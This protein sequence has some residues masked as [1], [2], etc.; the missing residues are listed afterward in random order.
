MRKVVLLWAI[1]CGFIGLTVQP[2]AA[3]NVKIMPLG[4]HAG[5]F[6]ARDR[7]TTFED[8]DAYFLRPGADGCRCHDC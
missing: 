3:V 6:C 5:E 4:S 8:P 7:A 1:S 2:A